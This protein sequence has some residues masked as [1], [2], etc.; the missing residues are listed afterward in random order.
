[1][2]SKK[3]DVILLLIRYSSQPDVRWVKKTGQKK[4]S[5]FEAP[6]PLINLNY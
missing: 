6:F 1:M 2:H 4:E 5:S 3:F